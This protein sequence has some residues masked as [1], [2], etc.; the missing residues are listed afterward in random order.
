MAQVNSGGQSGVGTVQGATV[1]QP[2]EMHAG[3]NT[4]VAARATI[5]PYA[6][7]EPGRHGDPL[8][9]AIRS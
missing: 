3:S 7:H 8:T 1:V 6:Q 2:A 4:I 9:N 5:V